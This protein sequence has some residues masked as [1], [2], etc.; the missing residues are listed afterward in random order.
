MVYSSAERVYI[1]E[2]NFA[3]KSLAAACEA[4][5]TACPDK[6]VQNETTTQKQ[7]LGTRRV[8][9]TRAHL[10]AKQLKLQPCR[11]QAMIGLPSEEF[12]IVTG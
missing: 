4:F 6:E 2:N 1:V 5:R 12:N 3:L 7:H 8:S 10:D 9:A 11:F